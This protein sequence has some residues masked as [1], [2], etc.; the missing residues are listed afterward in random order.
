MV[1]VGRG[2]PE[3]AVDSIPR[4][5]EEQADPEVGVGRCML[6][7]VAPPRHKLVVTEQDTAE[8]AADTNT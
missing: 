5:A 4:A 6:A 2:I 1:S 3:V 8:R 7:A